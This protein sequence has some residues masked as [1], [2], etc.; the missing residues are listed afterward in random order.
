M[1]D[2]AQENA[3]RLDALEKAVQE[4]QTQI[5]QLSEL[6]GGQSNLIVALSSQQT[7][8]SRTLALVH[9]A[10]QEPVNAPAS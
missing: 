8:A 6:L 7:E 5:L 10:L 2:I 4:M 9:A 1:M 3:R